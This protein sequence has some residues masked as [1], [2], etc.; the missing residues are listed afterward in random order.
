MEEKKMDY[1]EKIMQVVTA[2]SKDK[3]LL[4]KL[5]KEPAKTIESIVGV[6][7][8]DDAVN[9]AV[10]AVKAKMGVDSVADAVK[11]M[12]GLGAVAKMAG[13]LGKK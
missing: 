12:G 8:P 9:Q 2:V 5:D 7:L 13:M 10:A 1:S 3:N 11:S 4:A 6:D